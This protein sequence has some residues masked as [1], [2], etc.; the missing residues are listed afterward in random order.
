MILWFSRVPG[1]DWDDVFNYT[2]EDDEEE[3]TSHWTHMYKFG[4]RV[5]AIWTFQVALREALMVS[6]TLNMLR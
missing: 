4:D 5:A 2:P 3:N 1:K 6:I